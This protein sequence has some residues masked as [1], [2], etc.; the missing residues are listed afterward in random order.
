MLALVTVSFPTQASGARATRSIQHTY[1]AN[2]GGVEFTQAGHC[3]MR[4]GSGLKL[5]NNIRISD[6]YIAVTNRD[7]LQS[8]QHKHFQTHHRHLFR[9][10]L[11]SRLPGPLSPPDRDHQRADPPVMARTIAMP[12]LRGPPN[13]A[14]QTS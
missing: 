10:V 8:P 6:H 1:L 4:R 2:T 13:H 11:K 9:P 5:E 12:R 7:C 14:P 3:K